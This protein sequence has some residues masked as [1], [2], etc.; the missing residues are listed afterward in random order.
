MHG[1]VPINA[2]EA[3]VAAGECRADENAQERICLALIEVRND[4]FDGPNVP[5]RNIFV[6]RL[7]DDRQAL[8]EFRRRLRV[9]AKA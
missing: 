2:C 3:Y 1:Q 5:I 4:R 9:G 6:Y 8:L 7:D